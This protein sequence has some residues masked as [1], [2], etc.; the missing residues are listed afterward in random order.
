[1]RLRGALVGLGNIAVKG[2]LPAYRRPEA[3]DALELVAACDVSPS[4]PGIC[5][6][7]MPGARF[8]ADA[9]E[10]L[11]A[12]KPDFIDICSPPDTHAGYIRLGASG[13]SHILCEKPLADRY[14]AVDGIAAALS[15]RRVVFVPCHQ[16]RFSPLWS[17]VGSVIA[18]GRIGRVTLAQFNVYRTQAD[19]GAATGDAAWRTDRSRSGGGILADTGAHYFY[20]AQR[21]FGL[22]R[23]VQATLRTLR[24]A[25]YGVEDTALVALEYDA[26]AVQISLTWAAG[27]RGNSVVVSGTEGSLR[28]DGAELLLTAGGATETLPMPDVSDKAQ[29]VG[30]YASLL[31]E[32]AGRIRS[33]NFGDDL[34]RESVNV[35]KLLD[36]SYR[37]GEERRTL[38]FR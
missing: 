25:S 13:G 19:A 5:A 37:S 29:Y 23:S 21:F 27:S 12:E 22:P 26:A 1:V 9:A 31:G 36:L 11:R 32:F 6:A 18:G 15:G 14:E 30:W 34:F 4:G 16:Y 33:G 17:T 10:M 24:H 2:H 38:E 3:A 35:M 28:Y 7:E 8:Y 20:L